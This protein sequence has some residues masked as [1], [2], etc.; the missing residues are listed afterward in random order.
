MDFL[1]AADVLLPF[2]ITIS[3]LAVLDM[4]E[5][6]RVMY[7]V[8]FQQ[9]DES[10]WWWSLL[11]MRV[12]LPDCLDLVTLALSLKIGPTLLITIYD[13]YKLSTLLPLLVEGSRMQE[14]VDDK[15]WWVGV[16]MYTLTTVF[17]VSISIVYFWIKYKT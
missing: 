11:Q 12:V 17:N 10:P 5:M 9:S 1:N 3:I 2:N 6:V 7:L 16:I 4:H 15:R 8:G 14:Q 13:T